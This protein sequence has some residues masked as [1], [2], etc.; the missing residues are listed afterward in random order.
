MF[1]CGPVT[2]EADSS[3]QPGALRVK[4]EFLIPGSPNDA[5]FSQV[6]MFRLALDHLGGMYESA[7]VVLCLG[8]GPEAPGLSRWK[9]HLERTFGLGAD[10]EAPVP[11]RWKRHL[12]RVEVVSAP[13]AFRN[14]GGA[15]SLRYELLGSDAD[16]SVLCD[17]DTLILRAFAHSDLQNFTRYPAIRGV[18]AHFPPALVDRSGHDY[19]ARGHEWFWNF[20]SARAMDR[21]IAFNHF[22]TLTPGRV[23]SP[24]YVNHGFV[25]GT[26]ALLRRVG[27]ALTT[28]RPKIR[29]LLANYYAEQI[30]LALGCVAS[31]VSTAA[32]PVRYNFPNDPVADAM[33]PDELSNALVIHFLRTK[34]F[35][36]H[37]IF[38]SPAAFEEFLGLPLVGSSRA[39]Q[40]RVHEI[41]GGTYPF[42]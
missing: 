18:I 19:T 26:P 4:I 37:R 23:P 16:L 35:D 36:R 28:I 25:I 31:E 20:V 7:R 6:A 11:P 24:F 30:A 39:L 41:T 3:R 42:D 12:E 9:R 2:R 27:E 1:S 22:Y 32:L 17:A 29:L 14:G 33:Y 15:G 38:T 40:Q 10:P 34:H 8:A 13:S 5:F 21:S